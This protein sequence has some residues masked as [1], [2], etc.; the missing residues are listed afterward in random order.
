[1]LSSLPAKLDLISLKTLILSGCSKFHKFEISSE[2]LEF[3]HLDGTAIKNLP[4]TIQNFKKLVILNLKDCKMLESLPYCLD[5]LKALEELILSGCKELTRFPDIKQ[6][7]ENLQILLLDG[8]SIEELPDTLLHCGNLKNQVVCQQ[9]LRMNGV[10]LL[11]RLCLRGNHTIRS[12]GPSMSQ[13]YHLKWIDLKH[14]ENLESISTL[15]P[16]LQCLDAHDCISLKT[17]ASPV[18]LLIPTTQQVPSSFI[19]TNCEKLEQ[20]AKNE[21]ICY[22]HNKS[23][24]L[25]EA[26]NRHNK[27]FD[28]E[29]LVATSFPGSEVPA[30]FSHRASGAEL[31]PE[32]PRHWSENGFVGIAL[33]AVVSFKNHKTRNNKL[34]VKCKCVFD[35]VET[36]PGNFNGHIGGLSE[37][38]DEEITIKSNHVFIGYTNW[39]NISKCQQENGRKECVPTK[40]SIKFEVTDGTEEIM[41]CE[42]LQCGF[43]LVQ[44]S[45]SWEAS[46]GTENVSE[47]IVLDLL[48]GIKW[49]YKL[50]CT[51]NK[52]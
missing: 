11:R 48:K 24:L 26:L 8:T 38:C 42:V 52:G 19:F 47:S 51:R 2:N 16:N 7:M 29:A 49:L 9:P 21:I 46:A 5:K 50:L 22:A 30:W 17:V 40:A 12:L 10:S 4:T 39:L 36:S 37:T 45:G 18:A 31:E 14:C 15:P 44:E 28:F 33:C 34:Q 6:N 43:S 41:N 3:L 20:V 27:G 13:L 23:R 25:S 1:M 35:S 32:L